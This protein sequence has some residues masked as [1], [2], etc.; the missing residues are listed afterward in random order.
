[1]WGDRAVLTGLWLPG[2]VRKAPLSKQFIISLTCLR[3]AEKI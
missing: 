2:E 1:M 3:R